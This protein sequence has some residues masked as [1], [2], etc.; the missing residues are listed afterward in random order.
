MKYS[1]V[2]VSPRFYKLL[3]R[4][5]LF[6]PLSV[7]KLIAFLSHLHPFPFVWSLPFVKLR[8]TN[9]FRLAITESWFSFL[10]PFPSSPSSCNLNFPHPRV[11]NV[12]SPFFHSFNKQAGKCCNGLL[13]SMNFNGLPHPLEDFHM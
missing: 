12:S 6:A 2:S 11:R 3:W 1:L 9:K 13:E 5:P 10:W 4:K 8:N 7:Y